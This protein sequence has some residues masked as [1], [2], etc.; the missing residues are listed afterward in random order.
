MKGRATDHEVGAYDADLSAIQHDAN[1]GRF[2]M[3]P[4]PLQAMCDRRKADAVAI[5]ASLDAGVHFVDH[6][7]FL[8]AARKPE[9][10]RGSAGVACNIVTKAFAAPLREPFEGFALLNRVAWSDDLCG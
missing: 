8:C 9:N 4:A 3:G 7:G 5:Q 10:G 2:G 1:V 6:R